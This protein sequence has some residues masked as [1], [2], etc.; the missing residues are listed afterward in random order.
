MV[1]SLYA[2]DDAPYRLRVLLQDNLPLVKVSFPAR[3]AILFK[4]PFTFE[5]L[6]RVSSSRL[7]V[8][9]SENGIAVNGTLY[10]IFGLVI[11][12]QGKSSFR[13][14]N[15]LYRGSFSVVK[16]NSR[17]VALAQMVDLEEYVRGAVANEV[18]ADWPEEMLRAQ[19]IVSRTFALYKM[20]ASLYADFD[21]SATTQ[22][23]RY[24]PARN[25]AW[26]SITRAVDDTRGIVLVYR[27][28]I[29]PAF[30]H[31]ACGG[32]TGNA[33]H[34]WDMKEIPPLKGV[35]CSACRKSPFYRWE[36]RIPL[37]SFLPALSVAGIKLDMLSYVSMENTLHGKEVVFNRRTRISA[38]R[39][40]TL[41]GDDY[42][43]S[44]DFTIRKEKDMVVIRGKGW[45]HG[46]G[47]CQ[48]GAKRLAEEG[49]NFAEILQFYYPQS[50]L[51]VLDE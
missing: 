21:V 16:K 13:I 6:G 39:L 44:P 29:F 5:T 8:Q 25:A 11:E 19:A 31:A 28:N 27:G 38:Y 2:Q 24:A 23:Q 35:Y 46:V 50:E 40:R 14:N 15:K 37:T 1:S 4:K 42:L 45:G 22:D 9:P 43:R 17:N 33:S 20:T 51:G 12:P 26:P 32:R 36:K 3:T 47:L 30:F 34:Y 49:K 7:V 41:L 18:Y 48:W 10:K